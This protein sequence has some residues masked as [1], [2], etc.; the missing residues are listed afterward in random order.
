MGDRHPWH[1]LGRYRSK[2]VTQQDSYSE[3]WAGL[4]VHYM[5]KMTR[6]PGGTGVWAGQRMQYALNYLLRRGHRDMRQKIKRRLAIE[7]AW[8][9]RRPTRKQMKRKST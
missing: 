8:Y 5:S 2:G 7:R 3:N 4:F 1:L 9:G 6:G